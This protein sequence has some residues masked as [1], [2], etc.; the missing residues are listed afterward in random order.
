MDVRL[1]ANDWLFFFVCIGLGYFA[2]LSFFHGPV[3]ISF[4]LFVVTFYLVFFLRFRNFTFTHQRIGLLLM[5]CIWLLSASYLFY[6][7]DL[8]YL[9]NILVI[10]GLMFFHLV[11]ITQPTRLVWY[12]WPFLATLLLKIGQTIKYLIR[13]LTFG[14]LKMKKSMNKQSAEVF[15]RVMLGI[16]IALPLLFF[17]T[18]LLV[19]ADSDFGRIVTKFPNWLLQINVSE[20]IFRF[21]VIS[22][23]SLS[24]FGLLQVLI[25]KD[26]KVFGKSS[27]NLDKITW[28]SITALTVLVLLNLIYGLFVAVQFKYFF[29]GNL[30]HGYTYAGYARRGFFELI[31]VTIVNWS[32]LISAITFIRSKQLTLKLTIRV[33]LT[34]MVVFT[35]IML[36][37]AFL[38]LTMYEQAYGFTLARVIA[39][40]FMIFLMLIIAYTLLKVWIERLSLLHFY[41]IT[42]IVFYTALNVINVD[43][44]IVNQNVKRFEQ[45]G[46]M[47]VDYLNKLSYVGVNGLLDFYQDHPNYPNLRH[48]LL[49]RQDEASKAHYNWQAYNISREKAYKR[50]KSFE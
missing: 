47:D 5:F 21:L 50:L 28:N 30:Q 3:G 19:S 1:G 31:I 12:E 45:T 2:E 10:P 46:K 43:Q 9:L 49:V 26:I 33:M 41:F 4:V 13:F 42:A 11:L 25:K 34:L 27:T 6:S 20:N 7:N 38:R 24:F 29:S 36:F 14:G 17:V 48:H 32:V 22:F 8:F 40:S 37:S 15:K 39:H 18:I 44:F 35:T 16:I 23:Y